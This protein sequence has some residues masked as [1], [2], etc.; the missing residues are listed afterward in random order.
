MDEDSSI[1]EIKGIGEKT[2]ALFQKL[3]VNTA[4]DLLRFY[5]RA[6][7]IYEDPV[8]VSELEEG[9]VA[10]VEGCVYGNI[11]VSSNRKLQTTTAMIKDVTGT[12]K[13]LWFRMPFLR[14]T[15][16]SGSHII[17]R[18]RVV[19]LSLIHI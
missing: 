8:T 4:G 3:G 7:D 13:V 18:G 11:Q 2:E 19:S 6:Y 14:N 1:R 15:L 5:P 10:A 17:V 16:R 12:L 9:T